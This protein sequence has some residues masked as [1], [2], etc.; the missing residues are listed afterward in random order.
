MVMMVAER[1]YPD[2]SDIHAKKA[3]GRCQI[4]ALSFGEK[5]EMMAALRERLKPFAQARETRNTAKKASSQQS[6]DTDHDL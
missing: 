4:K 1:D 3:E 6:K 2:V 5:M